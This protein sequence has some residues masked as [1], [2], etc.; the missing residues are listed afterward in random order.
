MSKPNKITLI[1]ILIF[2]VGV[3]SFVAYINYSLN[4]PTFSSEED[5]E[6]SLLETE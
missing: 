2:V 4:N 6:F 3:L 1:F 5:R